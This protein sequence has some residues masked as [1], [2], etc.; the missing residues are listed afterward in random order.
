M[1]FIRSSCRDL[2]IGAAFS[3]EAHDH[4]TNLGAYGF[5]AFSRS[6]ER[7]QWTIA[8]PRTNVDEKKGDG[9]EPASV[10]PD[11]HEEPHREQRRE[12]REIDGT[13]SAEGEAHQ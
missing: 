7:N 3:A 11:L 9:S 8:L 1:R 6:R 12:G 10:E 13:A 5:A 4:R 2:V